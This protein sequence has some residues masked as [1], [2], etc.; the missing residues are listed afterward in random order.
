MTL[1]ADAESVSRQP[2]TWRTL[3]DKERKRQRKAIEMTKKYGDAAPLVKSLKDA[4][5]R[6]RAVKQAFFQAERVL[7]DLHD[8]H[9]RRK[10]LTDNTRASEIV[11]GARGH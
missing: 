9:E 10:A 7:L 3:T 5:K 2:P 8:R 1:R 4:D 6:T 11:R